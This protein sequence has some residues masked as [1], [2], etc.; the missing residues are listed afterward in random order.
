MSI[1]I[2]ELVGA[3]RNDVGSLAKEMFKA[4]DLC[5]CGAAFPYAQG[6]SAGMVERD[7]DLPARPDSETFRI[8]LFA[9]GSADVMC[10]ALPDID[11]IR[12]GHYDS[13]DDLPNWV[14]E[15]LAI[16]MMTD[17]RVKPTPHIANV[18][19]RISAGV[20][21]VYSPKATSEEESRP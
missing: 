10:F 3:L 6:K 18:G 21:W 13:T 2:S 11:D 5:V 17:H 1:R 15:R 20:F 9:D 14:Q 7:D 12:E 8:S 16:L 19:R 4:S